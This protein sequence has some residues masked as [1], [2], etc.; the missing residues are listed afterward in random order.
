MPQCLPDRA[1]ILTITSEDVTLLTGLS[2]ND[3][4]L[5]ELQ[6]QR[7]RN[8]R[9]NPG[10]TIVDPLHSYFAKDVEDVKWV[11]MAEEGAVETTNVVG[12]ITATTTNN[13]RTSNHPIRACL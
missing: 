1:C 11:K 6:P 9:H 7:R 8:H 10:P 2:P 5:C 4:G 12:V 13:N 3:Q